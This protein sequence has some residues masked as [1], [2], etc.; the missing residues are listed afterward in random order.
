[1]IMEEENQE[2]VLSKKYTK[3]RWVNCAILT[4]AVRA[5]F[6]YNNHVLICVRGSPYF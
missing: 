5:F 4:I 3:I 6:L 2:D 1:M